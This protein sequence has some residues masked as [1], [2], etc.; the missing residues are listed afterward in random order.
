M[1]N[2]LNVLSEMLPTYE[3]TLPFSKEKVCFKPF[4]VKDAK[5]IGIILQEDNKKL[6][7]RAMI[8]LIKQNAPECNILDLCLAD[9]E[10]LFLQIRSKSVD[11]ILNLVKNNEKVQVNISAIKHR[12]EIKTE[13]I[14]IGDNITIFLKTPTIKNLLKL[15]TLEK[16]ELFKAS[17]EK[18]IVKNEIYHLNKFITE[19]IKNVIDNL[20]ISVL[21]K[22]DKFLKNQPELYVNLNF[23]NDE[24]EVSGILN[25]FTFR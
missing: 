18:I 13:K 17:I 25:F 16:E 9:A 23:A 20:P 19:E 7:L 3:T 5:N 10:F 22:I 1:N 12:N 11:E 4:K 24:T 6:A 21:P 14:T 15:D 8:D 2:L